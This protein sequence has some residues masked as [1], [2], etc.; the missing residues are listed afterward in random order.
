MT[1]IQDGAGSGRA[2]K[3]NRDNNLSVHATSAS[4]QHTNSES[5]GQAYQAWGLTDTLTS[6]TIPILHL[7]NTSAD[8]QLVVTFIRFQTIDNNVSAG[9][10]EY[11]AVGFGR[12]YSSG[13]TEMTPVNLNTSSGNKAEATAYQST[14]TLA[15]TNVEIDR[16][17]NKAEGEIVTFNKDGSIVVGPNDTIEFYYVGTSTAGVA[18]ARCSFYMQEI[19]SH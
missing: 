13:G 7:K 3:V 6:A 19:G 4:Q 9:V 2:V 17:Y 10:G 12:T 1:M 18:Y 11:F 16:A 15:G 14:P 8:K 5:K